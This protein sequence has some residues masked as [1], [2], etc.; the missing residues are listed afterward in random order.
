M[1]RF[2]KIDLLRNIDKIIFKITWTW[3][4]IA[5]VSHFTFAFVRT[6][7]VSTV[8][9]DVA[10]TDVKF[11]FIHIYNAEREAVTNIE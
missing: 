5:G 6:I 11:T 10:V 7:C 1:R 8:C 3:V 4:S 2:T 9:I